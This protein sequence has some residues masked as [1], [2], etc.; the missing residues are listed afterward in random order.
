M[1]QAPGGP[2]G[3][4]IGPP[5]QVQGSIPGGPP[6][7]GMQPGFGGMDPQQLRRMLPPAMQVQGAPGAYQG[8]PQGLNL[9]SIQQQMQGGGPAPG[10][11]GGGG[12]SMNPFRGMM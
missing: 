3:S 9:Q 8:N 7:G 12:Q 6:T 2:P 11:M 5:M 1:P 10:P 4:D